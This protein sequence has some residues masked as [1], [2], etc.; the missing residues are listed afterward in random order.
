MRARRSGEGSR[1]YAL[2]FL[3]T[4]QACE[5]YGT[6]DATLRE[7]RERGILSVRAPFGQTR[8]LYYR[9]DELDM[10]FLGLRPAFPGGPATA[11]F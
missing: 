9:R 11:R 7:M 10:A 6:C 3:T 5:E 2:G 1:P 4:D 8:P